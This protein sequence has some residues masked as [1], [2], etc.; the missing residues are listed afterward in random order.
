LL[1][2]QGTEVPSFGF[3][4]APLEV[5]LSDTNSWGEIA[6]ARRNAVDLWYRKAEDDRP[7]RNMEKKSSLSECTR[8]VAVMVSKEGNHSAR[9]M[10]FLN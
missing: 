10:F 4:E 7:A 1:E 2:S 8:D 6:A 3:T 5:V 9:D